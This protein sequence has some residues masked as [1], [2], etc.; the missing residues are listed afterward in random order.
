MNVKHIFTELNKLRLKKILSS[1]M[2][3]KMFNL[4]SLSPDEKIL[5]SELRRLISSRSKRLDDLILSRKSNKKIKDHSK[6]KVKI[7]KFI[8]AVPAIIGIDL[9]TY[10][11]FK[12]E[13][14]SSI[15]TENAENLIRR[16]LAKEMEEKK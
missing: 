3:E 9:R 5:H 14:V 2:D 12:P 1:E 13:E 6:T 16:G 4:S 11:P 7:V 10:G 15:P 8:K